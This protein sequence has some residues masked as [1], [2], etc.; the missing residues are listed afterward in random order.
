M[1]ESLENSIQIAIL[2]VCACISLVRAITQK[3]KT[4]TLLVFF[5]VSVMLGDFYWV[6]YLIFYQKNPTLSLVPDLSWL[7]S[8][9]FLYLMLKELYP[10]NQTGKRSILP[11]FGVIFAVAM[12]IC[13]MA[14]GKILQNILYAALYGLLLFSTIR[15][16]TEWQGKLQKNVWFPWQILIVSLIEYGSWIASCLWDAFSLTN[17]YYWFDFAM[18]ISFL[19]YLPATEKAVAE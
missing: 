5:Y 7:A 8:Y 15:T 13:F 14:F 12:A 2:L 4:W 1:I 10:R 3:S 18:T 17:P 6:I 11:W 9:L 16:L 19:F